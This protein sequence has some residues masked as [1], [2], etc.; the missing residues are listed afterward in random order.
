MPEERTLIAPVTAGLVSGAFW[1]LLVS[2]KL[3][4]FPI[5]CIMLFGMMYYFHLVIRNLFRQLMVFQRIL[6]YSALWNAMQ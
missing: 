1:L 2:G 6:W 4:S 5:P 3:F